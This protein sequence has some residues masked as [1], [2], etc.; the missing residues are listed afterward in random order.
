MTYLVGT[1]PDQ[2]PVNGMLGSMAFQSGEAVNITGGIFRGMVCRRSPI[3][4]TVSFA[5]AI[6]EHWL[7]CNGTASIAVTLPSASMFVGREIMIKTIAAFSV[8]S[9]ASDVVPLTS[10][11]AGTAI[12][13]ATAGKWATLVSDGT[14]WIIMQAN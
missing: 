11:A 7:I 14:N 3:T 6:E 5:V 8:V 1:A 13:T 9:A 4:K 10:S 12:L 2:V